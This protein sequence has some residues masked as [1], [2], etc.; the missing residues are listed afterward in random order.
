MVTDHFIG[1]P[2]EHTVEL[3]WHLAGTNQ[4]HRLELPDT[5]AALEEQQGWRSLA[6]GHREPA[7][8][9]RLTY[10]GPLPWSYRWQ[11]RL[12]SH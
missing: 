5:K 11:V 12:S 6:L 2:G 10:R 9:V 8:V 3:F 4:R 1:P 7:P